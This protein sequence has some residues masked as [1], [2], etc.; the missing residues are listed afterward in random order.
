[1]ADVAK[2]TV[3]EYRA[4]LARSREGKGKAKYRNRRTRRDGI[5]FDSKLEADRYSE[6]RLMERAGEITDLELQPCIPLIGPSGEPVRG[7]N[8]RALTYRGD[9]GYVASD[10]RRVIEDVKSKPTKTAV[11]RL[12]KAI[13]AA[14]GVTITEIQRQDVG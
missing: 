3:Q 12:K 13:L 5:E 1:M 11:Y 2:I 14:Q 6:L 7:E 4:L 8:G 9:F 10:G